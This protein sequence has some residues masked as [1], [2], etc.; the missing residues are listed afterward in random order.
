MTTSTLSPRVAFLRQRYRDEVAALLANAPAL[1][2]WPE[3]EVAEFFVRKNHAAGVALVEDAV[4]AWVLYLRHSDRYEIVHFGVA[5][6]HCF[7]HAGRPLLNWVKR[8][9]LRTNRFVRTEV[10]E[11]DK[12]LLRGL[13]EAK[14]TQVESRRDCFTAEGQ[15]PRDGYVY[16]FR[17]THRGSVHRGLQEGRLKE[18]D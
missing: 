9:A 17:K 7:A 5:P 11:L 10:C 1:W 4:A 14:F 18:L 2:R 8:Q 15:L 6:G 12:A 3:A 16:D 13:H